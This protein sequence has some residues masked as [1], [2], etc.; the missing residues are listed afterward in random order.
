MGFTFTSEHGSTY[1]VPFNLHFT[2]WA[3][4][5]NC[6][7]LNRRRLAWRAKLNRLWFWI[8]LLRA[9]AEKVSKLTSACYASS[10]VTFP[11]FKVNGG[12]FEH[13][14]GGPIQQLGEGYFVI[15]RHKELTVSGIEANFALFC[16]FLF[17]SSNSNAL[18]LVF[19]KFLG[20]HKT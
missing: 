17:K 9:Q 2:S 8:N 14:G 1:L 5:G 10:E 15:F 4:E 12:V 18:V 20:L 11:F 13:S 3:A 19:I 16:Y 6:D 7:M